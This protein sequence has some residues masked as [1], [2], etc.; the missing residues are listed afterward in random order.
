M[1]AVGRST[2]NQA[3]YSLDSVLARLDILEDRDI[4]AAVAVAVAV[5]RPADNRRPRWEDYDGQELHVGVRSVV[6]TSAKRSLCAAYW[7]SS[8]TP[9]SAMATF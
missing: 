8:A 9:V 1:A 5:L 2:N 3:E 4:S 6:V 7:K